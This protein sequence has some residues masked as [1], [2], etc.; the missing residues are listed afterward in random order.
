[1]ITNKRITGMYNFDLVSVA[2]GYILGVALCYGTM[3]VLYEEH[4]ENE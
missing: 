1:M 3:V 4:D 2:C